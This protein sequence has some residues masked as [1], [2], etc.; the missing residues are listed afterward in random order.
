MSPAHLNGN[1]LT[2]GKLWG[3]Y[4]V[5]RQVVRNWSPGSNT[6]N[7]CSG[8]NDPE[9]RMTSR[10][11]R[12]QQLGALGTGNFWGI[13]ARG[14]VYLGAAPS[15]LTYTSDASLPPL[16]RAKL[17]HLV[18]LRH[19]PACNGV[20]AGPSCLPAP[21]S[22]AELFRINFSSRRKPW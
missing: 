9:P 2:R 7:S 12:F 17:T 8:C 6:R 20:N 3:R 5:K 1:D 13:T 22:T 11:P 19:L 14:Y 21:R 16:D 4:V 18:A 10:C 15:A